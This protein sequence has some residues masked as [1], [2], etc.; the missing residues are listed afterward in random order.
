MSMLGDTHEDEDKP[1]VWPVYVA[2]GV[3]LAFSLCLSVFV[4]ME[5]RTCLW[6]ASRDALDAIVWPMLV[7]P[8][9]L[10][11]L[12]GLLTTMGIVLRRDWGWMCGLLWTALLA[13]LFA[14]LLLTNA[15]WPEGV[16]VG[17]VVVLLVWVLATR[18]RLF[19]LANGEGNG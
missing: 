17:T 8:F 19:F 1:S 6:L 3:I 12:L 11:A 4:I 2:A 18:S 16:V 5:I 15:W 9:S 14:F 10:Y 13:L 7:A